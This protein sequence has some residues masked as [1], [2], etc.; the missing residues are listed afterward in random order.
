MTCQIIMHDTEATLVLKERKK[1]KWK[2]LVA[3]DI[4]LSVL[5]DRDTG[6]CSAQGICS[7]L[8]HR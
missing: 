1:K 6:Q 8:L 3:L 5:D 7:R 4:K 2:C